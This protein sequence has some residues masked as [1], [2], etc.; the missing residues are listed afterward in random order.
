MDK[1]NHNATVLVIMGSTRAGRVCPAV[2]EWIAQLGREQTGLRY[3]VID[4]KDWLLPTD[5]EPA[6]PLTGRYLQV[7]TARGGDSRRC[8]ARPGAGFQSSRHVGPKRLRGIDRAADLTAVRGA[9]NDPRGAKA[10]RHP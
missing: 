6:I 5:D 3:E 8:R 2:A 4:L 10:C 1:M 9:P 7:H